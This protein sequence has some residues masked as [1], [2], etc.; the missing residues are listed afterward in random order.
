MR[1]HVH[2]L[3]EDDYKVSKDRI[4]FIWGGWILTM[5]LTKSNPTTITKSSSLGTVSLYEKWERSNRFSIMFI[6]TKISVE[7]RS[8][9]EHYDD[10]RAL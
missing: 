6:K 10:V 2:E 9:I 8:S 3:K 1:C 7:I 4:S 5:S